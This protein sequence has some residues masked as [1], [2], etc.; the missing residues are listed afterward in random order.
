MFEIHV[1]GRNREI[2]WKNSHIMLYAGRP[3]R[4]DDQEMVDHIRNFHNPAE[5]RG[6]SIKEVEKKQTNPSRMK[7][8]E[9]RELA[10]SKGVEYSEDDSRVDIMNKLKEV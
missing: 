10:E 1:Y 7:L 3:V 2:P 6:I 5:G 8:Q 9:L 4:T